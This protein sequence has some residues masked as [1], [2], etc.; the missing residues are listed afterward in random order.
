M[1]TTDEALKKWQKSSENKG[2]YS[3]R[4]GDNDEYEI[5][6]EPLLFA[7]QYYLALYK[8]EELILP[9]KV[10]IKKGYVKKNKRKN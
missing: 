8:N 7:G 1:K 4:F 5:T 10:V 6:L 3:F 2:V 9:E